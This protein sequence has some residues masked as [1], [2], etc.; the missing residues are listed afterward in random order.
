M[1][2]TK[3]GFGMEEYNKKKETDRIC[4]GC[5]RKIPVK[6]G[7]MRE[8]LAK[9]D[10]TWGFFSAKDGVRIRFY[11]CEACFDALTAGLKVPPEEERQTELFPASFAEE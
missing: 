6:Q 2:R 7:I 4:N 9:I 1:C 8:E 3:E 10:H 5:G 11:L